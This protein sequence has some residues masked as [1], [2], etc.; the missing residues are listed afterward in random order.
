[1][2]TIVGGS[3]LGADTAGS[4]AEH[5]I[6]HSA[7]PDFLSW[8][9][10]GRSQWPIGMFAIGWCVLGIAPA[11]VIAKGIAKMDTSIRN[12]AISMRT[13]ET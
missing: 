6:V 13:R 4:A 11:G 7:M 10:A 5:A 8:P 2:Q 9:D 3:L 1:M 12:L